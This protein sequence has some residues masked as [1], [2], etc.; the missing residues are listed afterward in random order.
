MPD[1]I[2]EKLIGALICESAA[3]MLAQRSRGAD[4][5]AGE[6]LGQVFAWLW[7]TTPDD[8]VAYVADLAA[9]VRHHAPGADPAFSLDDVL[10]AVGRA[11]AAMPP[12][13][14]AAMLACL[15]AGLPAYL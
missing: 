1:H 15:R 6:A 14:G 13:E 11:S 7:E 9:Q 4:L 8:L 12:A 2:F 3:A 5:H 10:S